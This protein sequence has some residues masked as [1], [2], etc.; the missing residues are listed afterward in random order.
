[1][2]AMAQ[3]EYDQIVKI[4]STSKLAARR[5]SRGWIVAILEDR[6]RYPLEEFPPGI[7]YSVEFD[8]GQAIDVHEDDLETE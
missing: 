8:D 2:L 7:V 5:G 6:N 4:K 3:L 1:M